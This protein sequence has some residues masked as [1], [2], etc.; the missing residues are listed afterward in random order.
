MCNLPLPD[1][2]MVITEPLRNLHPAFKRLFKEPLKGW[3]K[4]NRDHQTLQLFLRVLS[5]VEGEGCGP[6]EMEG[7]G[8]EKLPHVLVHLKWSAV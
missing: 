1:T 7:R 6:G 8:E 2:N 3:L 4:S 5:R